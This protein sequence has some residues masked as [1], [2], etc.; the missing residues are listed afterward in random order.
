MHHQEQPRQDRVRHHQLVLGRRRNV[1][2]RL[3][4]PGQPDRGGVRT[5]HA[6]LAA[7]LDGS[8]RHRP[9]TTTATLAAALLGPRLGWFRLLE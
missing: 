6:R 9:A 3:V 1:P 8:E 5:G 2:D 4:V 7:A